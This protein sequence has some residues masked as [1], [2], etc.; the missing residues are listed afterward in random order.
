MAL[1]ALLF[2]SA[3]PAAA[4][5]GAP[6]VERERPNVTVRPVSGPSGPVIDGVLDESLWSEAARIGPLTQVLPI[7]GA[8]P[9]VATDVRLTYDRDTVYVGILC[10]DDPAEV[11][12]RQMDRDA[13]VRYDDVASAKTAHLQL[14]G[15]DFDGN[16]VNVVFLPDE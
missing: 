1:L 5:Q 13:F 15:R 4:V 10:R 11:R 12:A 7:E 3:A 9:T 6:S 16:K 2:A 14:H 8:D